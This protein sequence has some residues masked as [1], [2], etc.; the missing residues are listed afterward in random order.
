MIN[1]SA[2]ILNLIEQ[3]SKKV[4]VP[5]SKLQAYI[6]CLLN[7]EMIDEKEQ[8]RQLSEKKKKKLDAMKEKQKVA[9]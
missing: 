1:K 4:K 3:F 8:S 6:K 5:S 9:L 2:I 7:K